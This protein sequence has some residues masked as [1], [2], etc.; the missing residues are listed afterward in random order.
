MDKVALLAELRALSENAPDFGAYSPSSRP[1]LEWLGKAHALIAQWNTVEAISFRSAA[2]FL[3]FDITRNMNVAKLL[4]VLHRA[5]ADLE[6]QVPALPDQAFGPGAVYDFLKTL[7]DL[8]ASATNSVFVVDPYLDEQVFD[9]YLST[10][11]PQ[12]VVRLLTMKRPASLKPAVTKYI[13]QTNTN[14]EVRTSKAIH[15]R[16]IFLDDSS[17]WVLG[18]SIKDA[19]KSKPTYLAPLATDAAQLKKQDY[20]TIWNSAK[21]I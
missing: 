21:A 7:R 18:Q 5:I 17:C 4:G 6:L 9:A 15:D 14:V 11:S 13:A 20:E 3:T 16:V 2:D 19:A 1:H 10:V 12:V 8:L